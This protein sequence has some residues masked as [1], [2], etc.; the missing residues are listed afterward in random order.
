MSKAIVI[1]IE[2]DAAG[3][4]VGT[5]GDFRFFSATRAFDALDGRVF[6]SFEQANRAVAARRSEQTLR[7][8]A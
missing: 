8:A 5:T 7:K 2:G 3:I 4:I 6:R 1:E